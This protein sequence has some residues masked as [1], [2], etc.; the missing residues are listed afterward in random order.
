[1]EVLN[2]LGHGVLEK[3]SENAL[4][5]EFGLRGVRYPDGPRGGWF[6]GTYASS[7][8][9]AT[10][11]TCVEF[12]AKAITVREARLKKEAKAAA[13]ERR[14][15]AKAR[16][17]HLEGVS[18]ILLTFQAG[19]ARR[20]GCRGND[21]LRIRGRFITPWRGGTGGGHRA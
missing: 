5:V 21:A 13:A 4:V 6:K 18:H 14:R 20:P 11:Q 7:R 10:A 9:P 8:R 3:P 17:R 15:A 19:G 1:M 12:A 16:K 2:T